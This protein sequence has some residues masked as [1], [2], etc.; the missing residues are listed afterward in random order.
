MLAGLIEPVKVVVFDPELAPALDFWRQRVRF[1]HLNPRVI[2]HRA[3]P[4]RLLQ[5]QDIGSLTKLNPRPV[6]IFRRWRAQGMSGHVRAD[7]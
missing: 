4:Q 7:F 6:R 5:K 1:F 2:V 3:F